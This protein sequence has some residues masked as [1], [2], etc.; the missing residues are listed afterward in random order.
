MRQSGQG[1]PQEEGGG[2]GLVSVEARTKTHLSALFLVHPFLSL[3]LPSPFFST[4]GPGHTQDS[5]S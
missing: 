3:P 2:G 4:V 5:C 1:R